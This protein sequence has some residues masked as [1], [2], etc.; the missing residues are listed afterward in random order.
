MAKQRAS[1]FDE[2]LQVDVSNFSPKKRA[3]SQA[4]TQAQVRAVAEAANFP[5]REASPAAAKSLKKRA[6]RVYRTGR[7]VQ[8]NVKASQETVDAFYA[9]T[10]AN[11]G[12]VLGYTLERALEALQR[13]LETS[14]EKAKRRSDPR[15]VR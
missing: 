6:A 15:S 7:N 14:G 12:W 2:P 4:P 8:L 9:I 10:D 5:S 1:I 3:D 13:E 11:P